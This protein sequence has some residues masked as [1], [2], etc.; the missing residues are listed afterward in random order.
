MS[1]STRKRK[2]EEVGNL[3]STEVE[4]YLSI[5]WSNYNVTAKIKGTRK[6]H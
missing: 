4:T 2:G 5:G 1:K 3:L 6:L